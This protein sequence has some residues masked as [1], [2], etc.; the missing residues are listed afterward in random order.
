MINTFENSWLAKYASLYTAVFLIIIMLQIALKIAFPFHA[1]FV[2]FPAIIASLITNFIIDKIEK[3]WLTLEQMVYLTLW[4]FG[5]GMIFFALFGL[6]GGAIP[7]LFFVLFE[8]NIIETLGNWIPLT[9]LIVIFALNIL[10]W[11]LFTLG[12]SY[13]G[14]A[15]SS[16]KND[17]HTLILN[18]E[19]YDNLVLSRTQLL[20]QYENPNLTKKRIGLIAVSIGIATFLVIV[21]LMIWG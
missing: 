13:Q 21:S 3:N 14:S 20:Q 16:N 15:K 10:T 18:E 19:I 4:F 17:N 11:W 6:I 2:I 7:F 12:V 9:S 8:K 1:M 5:Y